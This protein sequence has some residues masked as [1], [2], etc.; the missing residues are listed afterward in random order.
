MKIVSIGT[1]NFNQPDVTAELLK[2][3]R[4]VNAYPHL[5]IIVVD[6]GSMVN[7]VP[8]W[9]QQYADVHFIRSEVN[10]GFAGGNNLGIREANGAYLLLINND[11]EVT[12]DLIAQLVETMESNPAIGIVSPKIHYFDQPGMLQYA[13]Y[14]PMNYFLA[15][16]YCIG[17]FETD[18]GQYDQKSGATGFAHGAAMMVRR[19]A[20]EKAGL[21]NENYFLYYEELDWCEKIRKAGY[22]IHT[23]LKAL[24]F[25]KE[26]VSVGKRSVLKEYF[27]TRNRILFIRRNASGLA[28]LIFCFYFAIAVVP[29]NLLQ[30]IRNGEYGFINVFFRAIFWHFRNGI[31]SNHLGFKLNSAK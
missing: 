20:I 13:G 30:Y 7:P 15:R 17:Q 9:Q 14:T 16:N 1:V 6:N 3:L 27:M 22:E 24:I 28:F 18:H 29:R 2:S 4:E 11:T 19:E 23:N 25:H 31:N 21:M 5:E 8:A 26:S 10:L 12:E